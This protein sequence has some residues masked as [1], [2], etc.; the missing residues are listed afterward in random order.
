VGGWVTVRV[1]MGEGGWV[2]GKVRLK[3]I[4]YL[5]IPYPPSPSPLLT[6]H[7]PSHSPSPT[8][9]LYIIFYEDIFCQTTV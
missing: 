1:W 2:E 9:T 6:H 3:R 7:S 8:L 5:P 4:P